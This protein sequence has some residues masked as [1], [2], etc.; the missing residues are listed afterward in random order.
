MFLD[1]FPVSTLYS[2]QYTSRYFRH[3]WGSD[4]KSSY[5][6]VKFCSFEACV[7]VTLLQIVTLSPF[8]HINPN[9]ATIETTVSTFGDTGSAGDRTRVSCEE[10]AREPFLI[11]ININHLESYCSTALHYCTPSLSGWKNT[12]V[13][14]KKSTTLSWRK[15]TTPLLVSEVTT[16]KTKIISNFKYFPSR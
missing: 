4:R 16:E 9:C 6:T 11:N 7:E 13:S 14:D 10:R 3:M 2:V 15:L 1:S 8:W 12:F 5:Q